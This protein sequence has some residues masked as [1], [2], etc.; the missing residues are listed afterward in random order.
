MITYCLQGMIIG[1]FYAIKILSIKNFRFKKTHQAKQGNKVSLAFKI[2]IAFI[3]AFEFFTS[4]LVYLLFIKIF[5]FKSRLL[6]LL[7]G[8]IIFFAGHLYSFIFNLKR[9]QEMTLDI[10]SIFIFS[11]A[12][13]IPMH[14]A[15]IIGGA[16]F[17]IYGQTPLIISFV[18][19]KTLADLIMHYIEHN[20]KILFVV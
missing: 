12:R 16:L 7:P 4:N 1:F 8:I 20:K 11:Y 10:Y 6:L 15:I 13:I 3:F 19:L 18:I 17:G 5:F 2:L 14:I 9:E